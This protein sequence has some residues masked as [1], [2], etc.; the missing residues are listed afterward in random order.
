MSSRSWRPSSRSPR[1][2]C[3][4]SSADTTRGR[5]TWLIDLLEIDFELPKAQAL[6]VLEWSYSNLRDLFEVGRKEGDKFLDAE[7]ARVP[8]RADSIGI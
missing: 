6:K 5:V 4:C 1:R 8:N 3:C 7:G 2:S